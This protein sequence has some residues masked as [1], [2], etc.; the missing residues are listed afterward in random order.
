MSE[1]GSTVN[2]GGATQYVCT[3]CSNRLQT[4]AS[5]PPPACTICGGAD[6]RTTGGALLALRGVD[7]RDGAAQARA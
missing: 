5:S 3:Q 6:W 2:G 4:Y 1:R 7:G